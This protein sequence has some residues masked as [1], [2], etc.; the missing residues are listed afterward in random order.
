VDKEEIRAIFCGRVKRLCDELHLKSYDIA[1]KMNPTIQE[2]QGSY[3]VLLM[4]CLIKEGK[5]EE[6]VKI[7]FEGMLKEYCLLTRKMRE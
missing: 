7:V 5:T 6:E 3:A 2:M 4:E 1:I